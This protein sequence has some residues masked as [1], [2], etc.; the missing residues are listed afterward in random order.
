MPCQGIL[1]PRSA[2]QLPQVASYLFRGPRV[3]MPTEH[4]WPLL[5]PWV[6][7]IS[8]LLQI[9]LTQ[10]WKDH[11]N[12]SPSA[13]TGTQ[14]QHDLSENLYYLFFSH[15][16]KTARWPWI[17]IES[18]GLVLAWART[19][20]RSTTAS[21]STDFLVKPQQPSIADVKLNGPPGQ[22]ESGSKSCHWGKVTTFNNS[23]RQL[24]RHRRRSG[25]RPGPH[26]IYR[27]NQNLKWTGDGKACAEITTP[28]EGQ[29]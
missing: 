27:N 29:V 20:L 11:Q 4:G 18:K 6:H 13:S 23:V 21:E 28:S 10:Q 14:V 2:S 3:T 9:I 26:T 19:T 24:D 12:S 15:P 1:E 8:R 16:S 7:L 5:K 25:F 22:T 17:H